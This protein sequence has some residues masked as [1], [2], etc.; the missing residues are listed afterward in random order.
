M[1]T[2]VRAI[3]CR[4]EWPHGTQECVRHGA[5]LLEIVSRADFHVR[6][7]RSRDG[8]PRF[9]RL[10]RRLCAIMF[11]NLTVRVLRYSLE[12][13]RTQGRLPNCRL[14]ARG[15]E[16]PSPSVGSFL[17]PALRKILACRSPRGAQLQTPL[18]R[19][20]PRVRPNSA[21]AVNYLNSRTSIRVA[22]SLPCLLNL[23][24]HITRQPSF[25]S[26]NVLGLLR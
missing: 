15:H 26:S 17:E 18:R 6:G 12:N 22:L 25:T 1:H 7:D 9:R 24:T 11:S 20:L 4:H 10:L 5:R 8:R 3:R 23:P 19:G 16:N 2:L 13:P 21:L 14:F